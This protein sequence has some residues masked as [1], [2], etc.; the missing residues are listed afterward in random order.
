MAQRITLHLPDEIAAVVRASGQTIS[1]RI[2]TIIARYQ[3]I[4]SECRPRLPY[5]DWLH[6]CEAGNGIEALVEQT[7]MDPMQ[8]LPMEL[9]DGGHKDTAIRFKELSL[10]ERMAVVAVVEQFWADRDH[11]IRAALALLG[12]VPDQEDH[13]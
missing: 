6:I 9:V 12:I 11:D 13:L 10:A 3:R 2:V 8:T 5:E 4:I 7:G 1:G